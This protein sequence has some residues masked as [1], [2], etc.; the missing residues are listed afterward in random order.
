MTCSNCN[1]ELLE[2]AKYCPTCQSPVQTT[3]LTDESPQEAA[4]QPEPAPETVRITAQAEPLKPE[5][6]SKVEPV[7]SPSRYDSK[8]ISWKPKKEQVR[9][10]LSNTL[11]HYEVLELDRTADDGTLQARIT[12]LDQ[13]LE[14]W[15]KDHDARLQ[16]LGRN[17]KSKFRHLRAD[18]ADRAAF[19]QEQARQ[20]RRKAIETLEEKYWDLVKGSKILH[21]W[22]W[23]SLQEAA[24]A[25]GLSRAELE[26]V[27]QRLKE[28]GIK[29]GLN[30]DGQDARTLDEIREACG[31]QGEKLVEV[32][33][34]GEL[35]NWLQLAS[36]ETGQAARV[37]ELRQ[38]YR[39]DALVGAQMWL[40]ET[41]HKCLVLV[42]GEQR[43]ELASVEDWIAA[44]Y[45]K[46]PEKAELA[47][48]A[49]LRALLASLL[50]NW[51]RLIGHEDLYALAKRER[52]NKEP[53][54]WRVIWKTEEKCQ[55][56]ALEQRA[57]PSAYQQTKK[58]LGKYPDFT[59]GHFYHA[60]NCALMKFEKEMVEHLNSAIIRNCELA[61]RARTSHYFAG[62]RPTVEDVIK[63]LIP[64]QPVIS[65]PPEPLP[66]ASTGAEK[67]RQ[68]LRYW[69]LALVALP[70]LGALW[71][72]YAWVTLPSQFE[73]DP[74]KYELL[75]EVKKHAGG[76]AAL[77]FYSDNAWFPLPARRNFLLSG[78]LEKWVNL[79]D[80]AAP[81]EPKQTLRIEH[82]VSSA[83]AVSPNGALAASSGELRVVGLWSL[84][85]GEIKFSGGAKEG[86]GVELVDGES[87]KVQYAQPE[88]SQA[89]GQFRLDSNL[90]SLVFAPDGKY[91]AGIAERGQVKLWETETA[92][93]VSPAGVEV[94]APLAFS[95]DKKT[96]ALCG[97]ENNGREAMIILWDLTE[98]AEGWKPLA[99]IRVNNA[100]PHALAFSPDGKWLVSGCGTNRFCL[101]DVAEAEKSYLRGDAHSQITKIPHQSEYV[102]AATSPAELLAVSFA[103]D[104]RFLAT[105]GQNMNKVRLWRWNG[106]QWQP[107]AL[108]HAEDEHTGH[109][110][111]VAF[112]ND[113]RLLAVACDQGIVSLWKQKLKR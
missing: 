46:E 40:W 1:S 21:T 13:A 51:L 90:K 45:D 27:V 100:T 4:R 35:E 106:A 39:F 53:G 102:E 63:K 41:G 2:G 76:I 54:L 95:P 55:P 78:G 59:E 91:L 83:L 34:N 12:A 107:E 42:E 67:A 60:A 7:A 3:G 74:V 89:L 73:P 6:E 30:I 69:W 48:A 88:K 36:R 17:G 18:L 25:E 44:V 33:Q 84:H 64:D 108:A 47:L 96:F 37:S 15:S 77:A 105:V 26:Q 97:R 101:W 111:A 57:K 99:K 56:L 81:D 50:D 22:V 52:F 75:G 94:F 86:E 68:W 49:S 85:S 8:T 113:A 16:E 9:A 23:S 65:P 82:R 104:G 112:S 103:P 98:R 5:V 29:T 79:W 110:T 20:T 72:G 58:L 70:L 61:E 71:W 24:A 38:K 32:F 19:D 92:K 43:W 14:A 10:W 31:G 87:G 11:N 62:Y 28:R 80:L 93:D 109:I 66:D